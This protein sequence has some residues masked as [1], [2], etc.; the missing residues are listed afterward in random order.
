VPHAPQF[1][2]FVCVSTHEPPQFV[3]PAGHVPRAQTPALQIIPPV[4][5]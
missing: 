5:V 2:P 4:Q 3:A 1:A